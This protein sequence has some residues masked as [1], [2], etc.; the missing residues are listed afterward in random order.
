MG[1]SFESTG[2]WAICWMISMP[3]TTFPKTLSLVGADGWEMRRW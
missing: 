2:T 3:L 1:L